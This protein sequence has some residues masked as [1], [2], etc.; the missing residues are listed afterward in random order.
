MR[1]QERGKEAQGSRRAPDNASEGLYELN[2]DDRFRVEGALRLDSS[3]GATPPSE[4][5]AREDPD[6]PSG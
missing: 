2:L 5:S 1:E 3:L 4:T 6:G